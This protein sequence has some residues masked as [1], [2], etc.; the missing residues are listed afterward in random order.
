MQSVMKTALLVFALLGPGLASSTASADSWYSGFGHDRHRGS[1]FGRDYY[2]SGWGNNYRRGS[3]YSRYGYS[4]YYR[5]NNYFSVSIGRSYGSHRSWRH[6]PYRYNRYDYHGHG[7]DAASFVGGVVLGSL[8]T[9]SFSRDYTPAYSR[10]V[11]TRQVTRV[12]ERPVQVVRVESPGRTVSS[13]SE[14]YLLRDL[15]GNCFEVA[16]DDAGNQVR[17]QLPDSECAF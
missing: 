15:Q 6:S 2:R 11:V 7:S 17:T 12:I 5:N 1:Y 8:L 16:R 4:P 9:D 13:R 10:P 3:A 14:P